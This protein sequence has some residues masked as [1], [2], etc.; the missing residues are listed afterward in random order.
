M[1]LNLAKTI[2]TTAKDGLFVDIKPDSVT[3]LRF[4]PP[5]LDDGSLFYLNVNHFGLKSDEDKHIA[6]ACGDVHRDGDEPCVLCALHSFLKADG[7]EEAAKNIRA[8]NN[9]YAQVLVGSKDVDGNLVYSGPKLIRMSKTGADAIIEILKMQEAADDDY[10]CDPHNGQDI[11]FS[12][13]GSGLQTKYSAQAMGKK[14]NLDDI[15]PGWE[16]K[17]LDIP[18]KLDMKAWSNDDMLAAAVRS[19]GDAV[20]WE[21]FEASLA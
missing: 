11:M 15:L 1:K 10:C 6:V 21:A 13:S 19:L 18:E 8:A 2:A 3:R 9:W 5:T 16:S 4:L 20:D 14:N 7:E 17:L 12:R